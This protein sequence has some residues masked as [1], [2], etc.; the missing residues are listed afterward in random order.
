MLL[1]SILEKIKNYLSSALN[2]LPLV[3]IIPIETISGDFR[4]VSVDKCEYTAFKRLTIENCNVA[5]TARLGPTQLNDGRSNAN[6]R[7]RTKLH[8]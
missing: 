4:F 2:F 6:W 3:L 8:S 1:F 5:Q 7:E